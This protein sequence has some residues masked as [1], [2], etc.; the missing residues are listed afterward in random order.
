M[1][2]CA[3]RLQEAED[4]LARELA[5]LHSDDGENL[6]ELAERRTTVLAMAW[7]LRA[8]YDESL[9]RRR[10]MEIRVRQRELE[11]EAEEMHEKLRDSLG[12]VRKHNN[13]FADNRRGAVQAGKS[14]Y[15]SQVS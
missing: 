3:A 15:V 9:L 5:A 14:L 10:L 4:L 8:G 12:T 1:H 6:E 11:A 2:P 7:E 13:Y